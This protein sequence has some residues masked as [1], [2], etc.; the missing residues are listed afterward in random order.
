MTRRYPL[1]T[2]R[3]VRGR[4]VDER[5]KAVGEAK[6]RTE[7]ADH[8]ARA[9]TS[10][11]QAEEAEAA[12]VSGAERERLEEGTATVAD[13]VRAAEF[14]VGAQERI[15]GKRQV[16]EGAHRALD[17]EKSKEEDARVALRQADADAKVV[18]KHRDQWAKENRARA[19]QAQDEAAEEVWNSRRRS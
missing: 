13:M 15:A 2:L 14:A 16:E 19:E 3:D 11:R 17:E 12:A 1:E 10:R 18:D 8:Q 6:R 4:A 9:A 7:Q 5:S